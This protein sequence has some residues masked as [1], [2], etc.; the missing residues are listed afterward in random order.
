LRIARRLPRRLEPALAALA[1]FTGIG[2]PSYFAWR[3]LGRGDS[4]ADTLR[5]ISPVSNLPP[6]L[7]AAADWIKVNGADRKVEVETNWLY[8]ELPIEF[9]GQGTAAMVY[10]PRD[11]LPPKGFEPPDLMVLPKESDLLR[12]GQAHLDG[13]SLESDGQRFLPLAHLGRVTIFERCSSSFG[14]CA[15]RQRTQAMSKD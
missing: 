6:D 12:T 7:M 4:F 9:Y 13:E 10:S 3:T 8:E 2:L 5:P 1:I 15:G 11:G 14:P